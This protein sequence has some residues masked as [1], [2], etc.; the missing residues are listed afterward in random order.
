MLPVPAQ[1]L[2]VPQEQ[3]PK[4]PVWVVLVYVAFNLLNGAASIV[5]LARAIG[6]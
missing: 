2:Q 5:T 6:R 1:D 4:R 3:N